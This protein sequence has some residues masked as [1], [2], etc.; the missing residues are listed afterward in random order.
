MDKQWLN[1]QINMMLAKKYS[2]PMTPQERVK[3]G[4]SALPVIGDALSGYDAYQSAK[5]GDYLGAALN[6]IGALP[7]LPSLA[8]ITKPFSKSDELLATIKTT[9]PSLPGNK[10]FMRED[11]KPV[12][13]WFSDLLRKNNVP[14]ETIFSG[15]SYGPSTYTKVHGIPDEVRISNHSKGAFNNQFYNSP[16]DPEDFLKIINSADKA[17]RKTPAQIDEILRNEDLQRVKELYP[18]LIKS[19]D[20]KLSKGKG[21]SNSEQMAVDLRKSGYENP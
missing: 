2:Q 3:G 10:G 6:A 5:Q 4:A 1:N 7:L 13:E 14:H 16:I 20:K 19:A 11:V 21:I 12:T 9:I 17:V 15:S 18:R 8:G